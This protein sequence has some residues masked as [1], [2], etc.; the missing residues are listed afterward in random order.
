MGEI[1]RGKIIEAS[2]PASKVLKKAELASAPVES[3]GDID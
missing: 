1:K 2:I 3:L